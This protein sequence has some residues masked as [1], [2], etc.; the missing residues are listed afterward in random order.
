M[1][2][3]DMFKGGGEQAWREITVDQLE[4]ERDGARVVDVREPAEFVAGHVAGSELVPLS[5]VLQAAESWDRNQRV[6]LVCRSGNRSGT[7]ASWLKQRGFA[8][9]VNVLG[10]MI[11]WERAGYPIETGRG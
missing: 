4:A 6:L 8:D 7:A 11:A 2:L 3:F 10:G 1:G 9:P 5:T